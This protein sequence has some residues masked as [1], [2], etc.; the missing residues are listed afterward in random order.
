MVDFHPI[1]DSL[2]RRCNRKLLF[3]RKDKTISRKKTTSRFTFS[4]VYLCAK[5]EQIIALKLAPLSLAFL[6]MCS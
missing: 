1:S 5:V 6:E 4:K 2:N 3:S